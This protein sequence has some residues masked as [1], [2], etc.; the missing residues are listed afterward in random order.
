MNR[1]AF[2]SDTHVLFVCEGTFEQYLVE[3]LARAGKLVIESDAI[4]E[5][6]RTR[7]ATQIQSRYLNFDYDWPVALVRVLDSRRENFTLGRL[8]RDRYP[9]FN[10]HTH[11]EIEML[12]VIHENRFDD[13]SRHFKSSMKPSE[14]CMQKLRLGNVKSRRFLEAYWTPETLIQA[15]RTYD[16][17]AHIPKGEL[18]LADLLR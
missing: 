10:V 17:L 11:P 4:I 13:Y 16:S 14:Y 3:S 7:S 18:S 15:I 12:I 6:T 2:S 9:V 1:L 5:A 8:Y